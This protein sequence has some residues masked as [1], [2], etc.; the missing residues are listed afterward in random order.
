V[1]GYLEGRGSLSAAGSTLATAAAGVHPDGCQRGRDLHVGFNSRPKASKFQ[2]KRWVNLLTASATNLNPED[3][4]L[5]VPTLS[6]D[7]A[8]LRCF[9]H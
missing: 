1:R 7:T 6:F 9:C 2:P 4:L 8:G 3:V 5:A